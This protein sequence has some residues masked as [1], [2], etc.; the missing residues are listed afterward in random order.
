[1]DKWK[2]NE[3]DWDT[4]LWKVLLSIRSMKKQ[5][6]GFTPENL[7]YGQNITLPSA[8]IA[9]EGEINIE[10]AVSERISYINTGLE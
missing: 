1:M 6:T 10:D 8:W 7:V 4:Y 3:E 9:P 5:S 2:D